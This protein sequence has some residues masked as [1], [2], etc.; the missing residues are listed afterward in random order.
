M[1]WIALPLPRWTYWSLRLQFDSV[2]RWSLEGGV[3]LKPGPK[4]GALI[5]WDWCPYKKK[6][7]YQSTLTHSLTLCV[8][9]EQRLGEDTRWL[10]AGQEETFHQKPTLATWT[11]SLQRC[12]TI[13]IYCSSTLVCSILL[14]QPK[15]TDSVLGNMGTEV[16]LFATGRDVII[17]ESNLAVFKF[18]LHLP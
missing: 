12:E 13:N 10:S 3:K 4:G 14:W 8:H 16:C 9:T 17:L 6:K 11:S 18:S 7:R 5:Q 1:Y 15:K 2:W